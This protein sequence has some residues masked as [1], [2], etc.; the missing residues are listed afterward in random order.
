MSAGIRLRLRAWLFLGYVMAAGL[1]ISIFFEP[2]PAYQEEGNLV[3][4]YVWATMLSLGGILGAGDVL[5]GRWYPELCGLM[6]LIPAIFSY[7]FVLV[8]RSPGIPY[9]GILIW[10]LC[11]LILNRLTDVW[12][13]FRSAKETG[14][15]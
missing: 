2:S 13:M 6:L 7:G 11:S 5:I 15:S 1:G 3:L 10:I 4:T 9:S 8:V 14:G 12:R